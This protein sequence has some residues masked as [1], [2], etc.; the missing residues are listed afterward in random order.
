VV[1]KPPQARVCS[2]SQSLDASSSVVAART[3]Q[4]KEALRQRQEI[5]VPDPLLARRLA[6]TP[7]RAI[8][9][10]HR[11]RLAMGGYRGLRC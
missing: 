7:E 1:T 6:I 3:A 5:G 2:C 11:R 8:K 9:I 4:L 10:E